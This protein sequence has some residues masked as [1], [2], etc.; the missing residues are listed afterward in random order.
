MSTGLLQGPQ[1]FLGLHFS[2]P[3]FVFCPWKVFAQIIDKS[4]SYCSTCQ[5]CART[6]LIEARCTSWNYS[7][8]QHRARPAQVFDC[9]LTALPDCAALAHG[10][11][12]SWRTCFSW[13][14]GW[15]R[16]QRGHCLIEH[17]RNRRQLF[18]IQWA[19]PLPWCFGHRDSLSYPSSAVSRCRQYAC[20]CWFGV[21]LLPTDSSRSSFL[22]W[23]ACL[24]GTEWW[25]ISSFA[26]WRS[27]QQMTAIFELQHLRYRR[28]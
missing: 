11:A 10:P 19:P 25:W 12:T 5:G 15:A 18:R 9:L 14:T 24:K 20:R 7:L 1:L 8:D 4:R 21:D 22:V 27:I 28:G 16:W 26:E 3:P 17:T 13:W 23:V 6:G 2:P